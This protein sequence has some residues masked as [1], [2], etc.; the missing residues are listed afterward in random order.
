[1]LFH[2]LMRT[3]S[4]VWI[5]IVLL[6]TSCLQGME[7]KKKLSP[8]TL[9]QLYYYFSH[10][11][12]LPEIAQYIFSLQCGDSNSAEIEQNSKK[13]KRFVKYIETLI[14]SCG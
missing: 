9:S 4:M 2:K 8:I 10:D 12:L 11:V 14:S 7:S 1:M 6:N 13:P 5:F 3:N